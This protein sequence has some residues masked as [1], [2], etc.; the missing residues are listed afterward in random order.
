MINFAYLEWKYSLLRFLLAKKNWEREN[1]FAQIEKETWPFGIEGKGTFSKDFFFFGNLKPIKS[2]FVDAKI[3][4]EI[5]IFL[6]IV[7]FSSISLEWWHLLWKIISFY[8]K[9]IFSSKVIEF[10]ASCKTFSC[11]KFIKSVKKFLHQTTCAR[12]KRKIGKYFGSEKLRR[13]LAFCFSGIV[14]QICGR[15]DTRSRKGNLRKISRKIFQSKIFKV[16]HFNEHL[17][18]KMKIEK[19]KK[20][21]DLYLG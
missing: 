8:Q 4:K 12:I 2:K 13:Q 20:L 15:Y 1:L 11:F 18:G 3:M 10:H 5:L 21:F 16:N 14:W 7:K 9:F 19:F 6:K 17:N